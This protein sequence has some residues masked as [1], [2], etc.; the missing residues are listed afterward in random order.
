[1]IGINEWFIDKQ[2]I[3]KLMIGREEKKSDD[4]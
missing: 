1:M 2:M 4:R 3:Q